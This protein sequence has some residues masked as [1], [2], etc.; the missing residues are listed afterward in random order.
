MKFKIIVILLGILKTISYL[1]TM[2]NEAQQLAKAIDQ[3]MVEIDENM[4]TTD[5][6]VAVAKVLNDE[7]SN[8]NR[9]MF[10]TILKVNLI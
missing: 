9:K 6:A 3:A 2:T 5:F 1:S 7:Y 10:L 4:S 8:D